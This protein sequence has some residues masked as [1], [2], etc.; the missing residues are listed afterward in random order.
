MITY[1]QLCVDIVWS[2]V[3]RTAKN[4]ATTP[5]TIPSIVAKCVMKQKIGQKKKMTVMTQ[6]RKINYI[7]HML[8]TRITYFTTGLCVIRVERTS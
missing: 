6:I 3:P 2:T 5:I 4:T 8:V 7:T 1:K